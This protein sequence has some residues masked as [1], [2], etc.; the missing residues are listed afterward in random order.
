M[1]IGYEDFLNMTWR[2]YNYVSTGHERRIERQWDY[3]RHLI[4]SNFNSSGFLKKGKTVKATDII[5]LPSLD[6][7]KDTSLQRV[8]ENVLKERIK[9]LQKK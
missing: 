7:P 8:D 1:G 2:E 4:A 3:T 9:L 5:T 6:K